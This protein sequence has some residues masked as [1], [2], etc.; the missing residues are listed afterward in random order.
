MLSFTSITVAFLIM[1]ID[2]HIGSLVQNSVG[3]LTLNSLQWL[4]ERHAVKPNLRLE[5]P[6]TKMM[7]TT[8]AKLI[9]E[10]CL[11]GNFSYSY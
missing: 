9:R 7:I 3:L 5:I 8:H 4:S 1:K 2:I 10:T 11:G 6:C